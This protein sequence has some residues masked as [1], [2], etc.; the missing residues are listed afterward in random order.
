MKAITGLVVAARDGAVTIQLIETGLVVDALVHRKF[1]YGESV[2]VAFDYMSNTIRY[3]LRKGEEIPDR[4]LHAPP[5]EVVI[6]YN[7]YD[8]E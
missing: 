6:D 7:P 3:I 4:F 2:K 8:Y 5:E 1:S